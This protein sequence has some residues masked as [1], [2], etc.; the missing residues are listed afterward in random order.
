MS[1]K[2]VDLLSYRIERTLKNN[3]FVC[4]LDDSN[5]VKVLIRLSR[6]AGEAPSK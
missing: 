3:G 1:D 6:E 4:K 5:R 2:I